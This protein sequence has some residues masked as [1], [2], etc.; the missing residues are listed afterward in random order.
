M[1]P[2]Q[3]LP[4]EIFEREIIPLLATGY[5]V[6]AACGQ[7]EAIL[8]ETVETAV[9]SACRNPRGA[10]RPAV[11]FLRLLV[12]SC[13]RQLPTPR[14]TWGSRPDAAGVIDQLP[15]EACAA[16]ARELSHH[17]PLRDIARILGC[18]SDEAAGLHLIAEEAFGEPGPRP[19]SR[20]CPLARRLQLVQ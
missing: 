12:A 17:L 8:F 4:S 19:S 11:A 18:S 6:A 20:P 1:R 16:V 9:L 7:D 14:I 3:Q 10:D 15:V 5:R 2:Q 13:V